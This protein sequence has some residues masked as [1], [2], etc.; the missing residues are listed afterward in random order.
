MMSLTFG[1]LFL[2]SWWRRTSWRRIWIFS[3]RNLS[4]DFPYSTFFLSF[5]HSALR[6]LLPIGQ[7]IFLLIPV[8]FL[9]DRSRTLFLL[10]L[11]SPSCTGIDLCPESLSM[12][13]IFS[14]VQ[15]CLYRFQLF[16]HQRT[17]LEEKGGMG[18]SMIK[19][20]RS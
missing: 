18:S 1:I 19:G 8:S 17:K 6:F 11:F 9:T 14:G 2:F 13:R 5:C 4:R 3:T 20:P 15:Y 16:S 7:R 12:I 10:S